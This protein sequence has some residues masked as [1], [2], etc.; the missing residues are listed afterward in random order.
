VD[1]TAGSF[2]F[3]PLGRVRLFTR[4]GSGPQALARDVK[5]LLDEETAP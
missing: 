5:M 1:H 3:D 4:Y 2:V